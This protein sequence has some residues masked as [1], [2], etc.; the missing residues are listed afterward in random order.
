IV[1]L[2]NSQQ[3]MEL[4]PEH[5]RVIYQ[6][7]KRVLDLLKITEHEIP[8]DDPYWDEPADE[9]SEDEIVALDSSFR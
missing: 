5:V 9:D 4:L 1:Q 7:P 3:A 6:K 2:L 8:D